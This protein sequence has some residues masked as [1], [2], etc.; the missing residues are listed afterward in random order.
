[1]CIASV[2]AGAV[3]GPG[4]ASAPVPGRRRRQC[5]PHARRPGRFLAGAA[6]AA[7]QPPGRQPHAYHHRQ[8]VT[9][10]MHLCQR[11]QILQECAPDVQL[12]VHRGWLFYKPKKCSPNHPSP[13]HTH[14]P[15]L[16]VQTQPAPTAAGGLLLTQK[17]CLLWVVSGRCVPWHRG[18][19]RQPLAACRCLI[20]M[21][22]VVPK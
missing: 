10:T 15:G 6:A 12:C 7:G 8:P 22:V 2:C 20:H 1:M 16:P 19:S 4:D 11:L 14:S 9:G 17:Q 13:A 18:C 5:E 21:P 3:G